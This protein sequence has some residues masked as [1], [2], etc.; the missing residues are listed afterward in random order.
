M[1]LQPSKMT[2]STSLHKLSFRIQHILEEFKLK[3]RSRE[4]TLMQDQRE[5]QQAMSA[6][7]YNKLPMSEFRT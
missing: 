5:S 1:R 3:F 7:I 6:T 2:I 4:T